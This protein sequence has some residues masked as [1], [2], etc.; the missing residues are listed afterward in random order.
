M[1]FKIFSC[2]T[3]EIVPKTGGGFSFYESVDN[4]YKYMNGKISDYH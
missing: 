1:C 4:G 2:N 3:F